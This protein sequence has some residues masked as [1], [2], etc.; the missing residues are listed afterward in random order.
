MTSSPGDSTDAAFMA[1]A[2]ALA[3]EAAG[4]GEV[5]V[6]A[7][8]VV[9]GVIV[10]RGRNRREADHDPLAHAETLALRDAAQHLKRWR[11][12]DATLYVTLEPCPMCAGALVN[13]RVRELVFGARDPRAGAVRSLFEIADDVRLNH[14]VRVREGVEAEA[15]AA[16]LQAFF[17]ARRV[18]K[19][20]T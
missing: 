5:P 3:R 9:G 8:V 19:N 17:R 1:E 14:R 16:L 6:G 4:E 18:R 7:V 11:L 10:G 2:L 15:S 12:H 13:A 20:P